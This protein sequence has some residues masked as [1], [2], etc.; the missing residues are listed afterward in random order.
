VTW[1]VSVEEKT[2]EL[3]EVPWVEGIIQS[4]IRADE[5]GES[6]QDQP[7]RSRIRS[8]QGDFEFRENCEERNRTGLLQRYPQSLVISLNKK[9]RPCGF[10]S[11]GWHRPGVVMEFNI[12]WEL[13]G[14]PF[15]SLENM[16]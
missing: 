8:L 4:V 1:S 13:F 11:F 3:R 12:L 5:F 9:F 2:G 6:K 10:G 16:K 7:V 14:S 15:F